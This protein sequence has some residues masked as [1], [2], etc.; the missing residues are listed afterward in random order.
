MGPVMKCVF[1][2][3]FFLPL[4]VV[5]GSAAQK[6]TKTSTSGTTATTALPA[7]IPLFIEDGDFTSTLTLVNGSAVQTYADVKVSLVSML[8]VRIWMALFQMAS[9]L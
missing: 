4:V 9:A 1:V 8:A 7:I 5:A 2:S 6:T 3:L